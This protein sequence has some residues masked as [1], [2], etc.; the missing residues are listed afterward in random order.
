MK[1]LPMLLV[2]WCSLAG[3]VHSVEAK[4]V[5]LVVERITP[6][7]EG[8]TFAEAGAFER[9]EGTVYMEVDPKD[10]RNA[11][12]VNLDRAPRNADGRVEFNAPFVIIKP[13]ALFRPIFQVATTRK[14]SEV[15]LVDESK[16]EAQNANQPPPGGQEADGVSCSWWRRGRVG[17]HLEHGT[18]V[19]L[20][21]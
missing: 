18:R 5:R 10:P 6:Y 11:V 2:G 9:L 7:A 3:L 15:G 12:V 20:A 21:A 14:G 17:L 16:E 8:R 1:A 13:T 19:M 4:V